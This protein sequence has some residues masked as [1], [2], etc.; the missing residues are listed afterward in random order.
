MVETKNARENKGKWKAGVYLVQIVLPFQKHLMSTDSNL[1]IQTRAL[2]STLMDKNCDN[3]LD[4][5]AFTEE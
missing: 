4:S 1:W 3:I 2:H 5:K